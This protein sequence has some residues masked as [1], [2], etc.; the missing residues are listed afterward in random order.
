[1]SLFF[2]ILWCGLTIVS[3]DEYDEFIKLVVIVRLHKKNI[4]WHVNSVFH[5]RQNLHNQ[6]N[7]HAQVDLLHLRIKLGRRETTAFKTEIYLRFP[8]KRLV[9]HNQQLHLHLHTPPHFQLLLIYPS[10]SC[11]RLIQDRDVLYRISCSALD[12]CC[13]SQRI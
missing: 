4:I 5:G 9:E 7:A 8:I 10:S 1:M 11:T 13:Q 12:L 6:E 3:Y 2:T